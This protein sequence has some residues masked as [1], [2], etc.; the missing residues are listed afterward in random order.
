MGAQL[1]ARGAAAGARQR[2]RDRPDLRCRPGRRGRSTTSRSWSTARASPP[3][4]ARR[5]SRRGRPPRSPSSCAGRWAAPTPQH[6]VHRDVKPAN[7]LLA[8]DGHVKVGDFG[9][10][11]LAEGSSDGAGATVVGTPRYMAPEQAR[12]RTTTPATDVYSAGIVLYEMI[13][14]RLRSPSA[15]RSSSPCAICAIARRRCPPG[16]RRR[17]PRSSPGGGEGPRPAVR[18][19]RRD[20]PGARCG[21]DHVHGADGRARDRARRAGRVARPS[22]RAAGR[23]ADAPPARPRP[24]RTRR[25]APAAARAGRTTPPGAG[26]ASR[27]SPPPSCCWRRC[28]TAGLMLG[29]GHGGFGCRACSVC[30]AGASSSGRAPSRC[31]S[32]SPRTGQRAR[33][34]PRSPRRPRRDGADRPGRESFVSCSAP[35]RRRCRFRSSPGCRSARPQAALAQVGLRARVRTIAAPGVPAGAVTSQ[36]PAPGVRCPAVTAVALDVAETPHWQAVAT[37]A[38]RGQPRRP[39]ASGSAARTG[40]SSTRWATRAPAPSSSSARVPRRP[41]TGPAR[42][43]S[44]DL[45]DGGRQTPELRLRA[46]AGSRCSCVPALTPRAGRPGS[47]TGT[48]TVTPRAGLSDRNPADGRAN[49]SSPRRRR[50]KQTG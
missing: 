3:G 46:P 29:S 9:V 5:R 1:R 38:R 22:S 39:R 16:H 43:R 15:P 49:R 4:C 20:G 26:A 50:R 21:A 45:S 28:S 12:G 24:A 47:R 25:R 31:A 23:G 33:A 30:A 34:G 40:G 2:P 41:S 14:G 10:A 32:T 44:F 11:R 19:R 35:G 7:I 37:L 8:P 6:I 36:S 42:H 13:A 48:S 18:R 27:P 17:W